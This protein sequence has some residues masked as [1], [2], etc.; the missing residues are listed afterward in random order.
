[1]STLL[2]ACVAFKNAPFWGRYCR[3]PGCP[4]L[5]PQLP[6]ASSISS[7]PWLGT[8]RRCIV[9]FVAA[10]GGLCRDGWSCRCCG[11]PPFSVQRVH[12]RLF[13]SASLSGPPPEAFCHPD[14]HEATREP[15]RHAHRPAY[16]P[17][18]VSASHCNADLHCGLLIAL[19]S[20]LRSHITTFNMKFKQI[21]SMRLRLGPAGVS[22]TDY[23]CG[24]H[25][26]LHCR[27]HCRCIELNVIC[28]VRLKCNF[29]ES[30]L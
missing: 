26:G 20:M 5:G 29:F 21:E 18:A 30:M 6:P 2:Q 3:A 9:N 11:S 12:H 14:R 8:Q 28:I 13:A 25:C 7:N 17:D 15:Q 16:Q 24:W 4:P 10:L 1:M 19:R 27:L 22:T 23:Y